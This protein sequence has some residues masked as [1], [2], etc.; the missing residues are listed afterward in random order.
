MSSADTRFDGVAVLQAGI[1]PS[2][3]VVGKP[4][5]AA[6]GQEGFVPLTTLGTYFNEAFNS[7]DPQIQSWTRSSGG[8]MIWYYNTQ[9]PAGAG[10]T[11]LS[12]YTKTVFNPQTAKLASEDN[13]N[14][15]DF[16]FSIV[17]IIRGYPD[18]EGVIFRS[19]SA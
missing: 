11:F 16:M 9:V 1:S 4:V 17:N 15:L 14:L 5:N 8:A 6:E 3:I 13:Q 19:R 12:T 10:N 7:A 18:S 2:Y